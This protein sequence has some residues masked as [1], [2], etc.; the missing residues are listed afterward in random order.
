M[1]KMK[2]LPYVLLQLMQLYNIFHYFRKEKALFVGKMEKQKIKA[3]FKL[4]MKSNKSKYYRNIFLLHFCYVKNLLKDFAQFSNELE[5]EL[6]SVGENL[7]HKL[8]FD[9][10]ND[11]RTFLSLNI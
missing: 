9:N 2:D 3:N 5:K 1:E 4:C 7:R 11:R 8:T 6:K 10:T